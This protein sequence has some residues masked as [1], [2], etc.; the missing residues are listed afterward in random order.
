MANRQTNTAG[1]IEIG[2]A[3]CKSRARI[4]K[5]RKSKRVRNDSRTYNKINL[6]S[7][8]K[9]SKLNQSFDQYKSKRKPAYEVPHG[10]PKNPSRNSKS[11]QSLKKFWGK[12]VQMAYRVTTNL[13]MENNSAAF[14][15]VHSNFKPFF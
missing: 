15:K 2:R 3:D 14:E 5:P 8:N 12:R 1:L 11:V 9:L 6:V 4:R 7:K 13:L 10:H